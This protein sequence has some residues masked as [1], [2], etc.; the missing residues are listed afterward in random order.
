MLFFNKCYPK[1]IRVMWFTM[2]FYD[3]NKN[4]VY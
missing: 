1:G 2:R 3:I 4:I